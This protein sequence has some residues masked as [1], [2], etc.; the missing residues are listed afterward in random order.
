MTTNP[1]PVTHWA[2][3][4]SANLPARPAPTAPAAADNPN[5]PTCVVDSP[6]AVNGSTIEVAHSVK[7]MNIKNATTARVRST[8]TSAN[9]RK[10][11]PTNLGYAT[12]NPI[13]T[14]PV[15]TARVSTGRGNTRASNNAITTVAPADTAYTTR[16][17][18]RSANVPET[19]R[20][21]RSPTMM[22]LVTCP[23]TRPRSPG[24]ASTAEYAT[25]T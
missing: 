25:N 8:E 17:P 6:R 11:D 9:N 19:V 3:P 21:N 5:N 22:P 1:I 13:P 14:G 16:H 4:R 10:T 18:A 15:F 2:T 23:T 20:A 24:A 7:A 12:T